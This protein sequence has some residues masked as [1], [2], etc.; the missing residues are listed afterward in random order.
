VQEKL[1]REGTP[2]KTTKNEDFPLRGY[3]RC[4]DCMEIMTGARSKGEMGVYYYYYRCDS[5]SR[6]NVNAR[7]VDGWIEETLKSLSIAIPVDYWKHYFKKAAT[8]IIVEKNRDWREAKK[9]LE[10]VNKDV[11]S[12]EEKFIKGDLDTALYKKWKARYETQ[13]EQLQKK[14]TVSKIDM[15][16]DPVQLK[17][18]IDRFSELYDIYNHKDTVGKQELLNLIMLGGLY[19]HKGFLQAPRLNPLF[20]S[21]GLELKYLRIKKMDNIIPI[22]GE[23]PVSTP[24]GRYIEPYILGL[25][26]FIKSA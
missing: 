19:S 22:L 23:T 5:C 2:Q 14:L 26:H 12:L 10:G 16:I 9:Q 8:N 24:L 1:G 20:K 6:K 17:R 21:N 3:L 7:K 4:A 11:D 15:S 25:F 18:I 13:R